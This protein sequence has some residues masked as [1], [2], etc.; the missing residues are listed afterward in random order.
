MSEYAENV[1]ELLDFLGKRGITPD[2]QV[3][4]TEIAPLDG[5]LTLK[6]GSRVV[7]MSRQV[8]NYVWVKHAE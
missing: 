6:V 1:A 7:S 3:M 4:I 8:A 2:A 5:P